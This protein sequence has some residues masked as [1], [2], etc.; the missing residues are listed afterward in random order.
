M[1]KNPGESHAPLSPAADAHG[2]RWQI[3][4]KTTKVLSLSPG[5]SNL[6]NK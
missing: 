1:F 3:D 2:N 6:I 5:Q 4:S